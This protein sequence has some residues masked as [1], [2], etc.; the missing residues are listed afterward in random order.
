VTSGPLDGVALLLGIYQT[1]VAFHCLCAVSRLDIP[2]KL[3]G[4]ERGIA[5]L[6]GV[7]G[8]SEDALRRVLKLLAS[9]G[10]FTFDVPRDRA[11]LTAAGQ[12]LCRSHPMSLRATFA[13][14]GI[15]DVAHQ[16]AETIRTGMPATQ[17]AVGSGFWDHL[18]ASTQQQL[19]FSEAMTEQARLL[20]LPCVALLDWPHEGTVADIGGGAGALLGEV[21]TEEP[22]LRGILIDQAEVLERARVLLRERGVADRCVTLPGDLF[23]P[24]PPAD[25]YLLSRVLHDWDDSSVARILSAVAVGAPPS[26]KLRIFEDVLPALDVPS[27]SQNWS[28]VVMMALYEGGRERTADEFAGLLRVGGWRLGTVVEGPPGMAVIE[29]SRDR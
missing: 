4:G 21:L 26:A 10:V 12:V 15:S 17:P 3:A 14:F 8:V 29:A 2:D 27:P 25:I 20:T 19:T 9:R 11:G 18:A 23:T 24:P 13:T 22:G 6:A 7:A 1:G 28:D 16:L 5:D